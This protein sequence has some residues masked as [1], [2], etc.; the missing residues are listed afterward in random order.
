M[1][2]RI[3]GHSHGV[4]APAALFPL[5]LKLLCM[6]QVPQPDW[7]GQKQPMQGAACDRN[8]IEWILPGATG[9][10]MGDRSALT[11][12][13]AARQAARGCMEPGPFHTGITGWAT[14]T[15]GKLSKRSEHRSKTCRPS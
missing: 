5:L 13:L 7:T 2:V 15:A 9:K 14:E 8:R 10:S 6:Q 4:L 1:C 3:R 11:C 12:P